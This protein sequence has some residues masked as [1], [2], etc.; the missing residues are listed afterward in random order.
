MIENGKTYRLSFL[1]G[2]RTK[3]MER[4]IQKF[5]EIE[6][7]M[8]S[9]HNKITVK[10]IKTQLSDIFQLLVEIHQDKKK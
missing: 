1:D 6:E 8:Y 3:L 2:R 7:L 5:S 9:L 10:E 4:I